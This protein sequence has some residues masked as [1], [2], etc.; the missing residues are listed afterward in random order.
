MKTNDDRQYEEDKEATKNVG[1]ASPNDFFP[2]STR[3]TRRA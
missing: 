1:K 3:I 2:H